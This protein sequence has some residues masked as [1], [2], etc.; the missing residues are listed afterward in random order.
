MVT[1]SDILRKQTALVHLAAEFFSLIKT[2][3]LVKVY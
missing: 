1:D 2:A 3:L